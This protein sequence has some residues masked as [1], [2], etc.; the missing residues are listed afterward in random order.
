MTAQPA[1]QPARPRRRGLRWKLTVMLVSVSVG[2]LLF[3]GLVNYLVARSLVVDGVQTQLANHQ[4]AQ[5]RAVRSGL[6]RVDGQ[7]STMARDR[8]TVESLQDFTRAYDDV[9][10]GATLRPDQR[11]ALTSFYDA[12]ED[13][14]ADLPPP[15]DPAA[16]YLQYHYLVRNPNPP[17][18]RD[19]L[20]EA[21]GDSSAYAD[22]HAARHPAL[23]AVRGSLGLDDLLLIDAEGAIVYTTDKRPDF[24]RDLDDPALADTSLGTAVVDELTRAA[25][26]ATVFVDFAPYPLAGD[27]PIMFAAAT[28]TD[29]TEVIGA[30]AGEIPTAVL[31]D[32]TTSGGEWKRDGLGDTGEV[33]IVGSDRLMRSDARLW[34]EDPEAFVAALDRAGYAPALAEAVTAAGTTAGVQPASTEAV[35]DAFE[36]QTFVGRTR[37]YLGAPTLT[38][39]GPLGVGG[40]DWIVVADVAA[41]EA[42]AVLRSLQRW[43]VLVLLIIVPLLAVAGRWLARR[44]TRTIRPVVASAAAVAGGDLDTQIP[45]RGSTEIADVGRRLAALAA[46]LRAERAARADEERELTSLLRS[47]L[48]ERLAA[49]LQAGTLDVAELTDTATVVAVTVT[50]LFDTPGLRQDEAVE[51]SARVSRHLEAAAARVGAERVRSAS[52]H[53]MFAAGL[54]SPDAAV[55]AAARFVLEVPAV[56]DAIERETGVTIAHHAGVA[57]GEVVAGLVH[58]ESLTYGVFGAPVR[59]ALALA[60]VAPEGRAL[61]DASAADVL[62]DGWVLEPSEGLVDLRGAELHAMVLVGHD[63]RDRVGDPAPGG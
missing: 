62:G 22:V 16:Q 9:A 4:A 51:L 26:G 24:A 25:A 58:H 2:A 36:G 8:A 21:P 48:P 5:V 44:V 33:Y 63:D 20:V 49:Q 30:V 61:V 14:V 10:T 17:D 57:A 59:T 54:G 35:A 32:L 6:E 47:V 1:A 23:D 13:G 12:A 46:D 50:G 40:L 37:N 53:H 18:A 34:L 7:I 29:G 28:V 52:D 19:A 43:V 31:S 42:S 41:A 27:R 56:L 3:V 45:T 38:A 55:E 11:D 39:A 15:V 60:A